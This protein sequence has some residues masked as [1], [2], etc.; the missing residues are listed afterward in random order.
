[1]EHTSPPAVATTTT[2]TEPAA[3]LGAGRR[4]C[5]GDGR[6]LRVALARTIGALRNACVGAASSTAELLGGEDPTGFAEVRVGCSYVQ[7]HTVGIIESLDEPRH[8]NAR[9]RSFN[10]LTAPFRERFSCFLLLVL[11]DSNSQRAL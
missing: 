4:N 5:G 9:L 8:F 10:T 1:M 3:F 2:P 11:Y 7:L 6:E